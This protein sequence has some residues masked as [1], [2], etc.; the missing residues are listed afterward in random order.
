MDAC[1]QEVLTMCYMHPVS[2]YLFNN[3]FIHSFWIFL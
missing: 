1:A 3:P 2:E